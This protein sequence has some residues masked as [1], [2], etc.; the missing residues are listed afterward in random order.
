MGTVRPNS[1]AF[2][3]DTAWPSQNPAWR[4]HRTWEL[5]LAHRLACYK[6]PTMFAAAAFIRPPRGAD[7]LK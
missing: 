5:W 7:L 6:T 4:L 2:P 1:A 3:R